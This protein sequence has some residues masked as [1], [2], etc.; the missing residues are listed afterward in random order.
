MIGEGEFCHLWG[1]TAVVDL[2]YLM[3][4]SYKIAGDAKTYPH[5]D[6]ASLI[7]PKT[8]EGL[9]RTLRP[10]ELHFAVECGH[11][12]R[13]ALYPDYKNRADKDEDLVNEIKLTIEKL[14]SGGES[15]LF[16][17]GLEADDVM[18][19]MVFQNDDCILVTDDKDMDQ[20]GSQCCLF[21][22]YARKYVTEEMIFEKWGI[23]PRLVGD[24][25]ALMGD[26]ADSVPGVP[27]IGIKTAARLINEYGCVDGIIEVAEEMRV[28]TKKKMWKN[29]SENT[30]NIVISKMLVELVA[31]AD[32]KNATASDLELIFTHCT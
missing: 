28:K 1:K 18:A 20:L 5:P 3:H 23:E 12:H 17:E 22:P 21:R 31:Y 8:I 10:K 2:S 13:N 24:A 16:A 11:D 26:K 29:I 9:R 19:T 14:V 7:V 4:R 15:V 6:C 32:V 25:L 30:T 27:G